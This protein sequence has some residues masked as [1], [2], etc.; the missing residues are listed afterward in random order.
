MAGILKP[1]VVS[2][3]SVLLVSCDGSSDFDASP[4][5][6]PIEDRTAEASEYAN[7]QPTPEQTAILKKIKSDCTGNLTLLLNQHRWTG[8]RQRVTGVEGGLPVTESIGPWN[9]ALIPSDGHVIEIRGLLFAKGFTVKLDMDRDV[10]IVNDVEFRGSPIS[11]ESPMF[12]SAPF[13]GVSFKQEDLG[14]T[15]GSASILFLDD[16]RVAMDFH[17]VVVNGEKAGEYGVFKRDG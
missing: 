7:W 17:K 5:M 2:L 16:G 4:V 11:G 1:S 15:M 14:L 12:Q 8:H 6:K 10:L 9:I 3:L 13:Q